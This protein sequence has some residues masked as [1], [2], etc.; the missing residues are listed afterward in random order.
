[1]EAE[2]RRYPIMADIPFNSSNKYQ[3]SVH[4]D[5]NSDQYLLVMKGAWGPRFEGRGCIPADAKAV[6]VG[7]CP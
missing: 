7:R 2:R 4:E 1:M 6:A 5:P 3:V